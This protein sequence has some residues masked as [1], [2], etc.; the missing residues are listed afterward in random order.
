MLDGLTKE[1]A[2]KVKEEVKEAKELPEAYSTL[3]QM[4][5]DLIEDGS[6][7]KLIPDISCKTT[8]FHRILKLAQPVEEKGIKYPKTFRF[9]RPISPEEYDILQLEWRLRVGSTTGGELL[10]FWNPVFMP[11]SLN[12]T[13]PIQLYTL[14]RLE[15]EALHDKQVGGA[16]HDLGIALY[17]SLCQEKLGPHAQA[18]I[19]E[20]SWFSDRLSQVEIKDILTLFPK[21]EQE[22]LAL[23][24]GRAVVGRS[25][26]IPVGMKDPILHSFRTMP[27]LFG[28]EPGQGKSTLAN[29]L[30]Q[31]LKSVGY[32]VAN[33]KNLNS[34]FNLGSVINSNIAYRDDMTSKSLEQNLSAEDTK[35]A[36]TNAQLRVEDKGVN[37]VEIWSHA[38][39]FTNINK[40]DQGM[41]YKLD[42]GIIDRIALVATRFNIELENLL[43]RMT[44]L[45][46]GTPSLYP[47]LHIPYLAEKLDV[48]INALMLYFLRLCAD[49][50][51]ALMNDK[52]NPRALEMAVKSAKSKLRCQFNSDMLTCIT[53]GLHLSYMVRQRNPDKISIPEL[54]SASLGETLKALMFIAV[55]KRANKARKLIEQDWEDKD[56]PD[57]HPWKAIA[58]LK[59]S[60]ICLAY[61]NYVQ[62]HNLLKSN[63]NQ[64]IKIVFSSL[65]LRDGFNI[66]SGSVYVTS[67]WNES[68]INKV[69]LQTLALKVQDNL[70][71]SEIMTLMSAEPD[72]DHIYKFESEEA[73]AEEA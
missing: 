67:S 37:A 30:I 15:L 34:R 71:D 39:F 40:F 64:I 50:F 41:I 28:A 35:S 57:G 48:S 49:K 5:K 55:D 69:N 33:F 51:I 29:Y 43:P 32:T 63:V 47:F 11:K 59:K 18:F 52:E 25:N 31:A 66:G 13:S 7:V 3:Y 61:D 1:I 26:H 12:A 68:Q 73:L 9:Y 17:P 24:F 38:F 27:I 46:A 22:M 20:K 60:S 56:R 8:G 42:D 23:C 70:D 21:P 36:I 54:T 14:Q 65:S 45:S 62:Q 19:P 58:R 53:N 44:G 6:K 72:V 10:E 2:E 16:T 4:G